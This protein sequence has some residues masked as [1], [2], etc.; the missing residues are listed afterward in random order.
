M[1][2]A[3][4]SS[5]CRL[6]IPVAVVLGISATGR[7]FAA[8][9]DKPASAATP[10]RTKD[11]DADDKLDIKPYTG[12]PIFLDEPDAAPAPTMV[13]RTVQSDKYPDGKLLVERQIAKYSDNHFV[14]DG[15]YR[16]YYA[17]GQKF[18]E[19]Q[20][21]SGRQDGQWTYWHENGTQ[22]RQVTFKD[23][24]PDGS[25]EVHRADGSLAT[26]RGFKEG[27][28]EG[29]WT[30]YDD[31][32]KQPLR[33]ESYVDGKPD[34]EWKIWFPSGQLQR[35]INFKAGDRSGPAVEWDEKGNKRIEMNYVDG[36]PDGTA[37]AWT[38]DG[39]KSVQHFKDGKLVPEPSQQ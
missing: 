31:T 33:L 23:G 38:A 39:R 25:W 37:T 17:N 10:S 24:M 9:S 32:G 20:Y 36:K 26:T 4:R 29:I 19:G 6:V 18:V 15:F 34:G 2:H 14:A 28:R 3:F 8:A 12:P 1:H 35:Q 5:I 30:I 13:D 16:E 7:V 27:K 22:N 21:K 11:A